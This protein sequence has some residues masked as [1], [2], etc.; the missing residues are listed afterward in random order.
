MGLRKFWVVALIIFILAGCGNPDAETNK[1]SQ[2]EAENNK[3]TSEEGEK[4][5]SG[6]LDYDQFTIDIDDTIAWMEAGPGE[7]SGDKYDAQAVKEEIAQWPEGLS[8]EEY[9][10]RILALTAEDFTKY[11]EFLDE[12]EVVFNDMTAKPDG[13]IGEEELENHGSLNVQILLDAS[14]S[15]AQEIDGDIKMDLAKETIADFASNLPENANVSLRVYGHKGTNKKD[16]KEESCANTEEVYALGSYE[17]DDFEK[18]LN[19]FEPTGYT[20]IAK[21]IEEAGEDL[22]NA[23]GEETRSIV[24][25]VSDGEETCGGDPAAA[26]KDLQKSD[27]EAIVNIIGLD[28]EESERESLEEIA[29]AGEG[30]YFSAN[31]AKEL[32]E[33]FEKARRELIKDWYDWVSENVDVYYDQQSEYVDDSYDYES[34]AVN[35]SYD[36]ETRQK[37]L[38]RYM[39]DIMEEVDA[40]E[41]RNLIGDRAYH[42][43]DH[44]RDEYYDIR[45]EARDTGYELREKA[46]DEGY[47]QREELRDQNKN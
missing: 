15:M 40:V 27:I 8:A 29:S 38:T 3:E 24:Y 5:T 25:V 28:I 23:N 6:D 34:E 45:E 21:A 31:N 11:Q 19:Q 20:P 16:G 17:E 41:I 22:A 12:T 4:D 37:D 46:R 18:S 35:L 14:G 10:H 42:I 7:Y 1:D 32:Q 47:E 44:V 30:E 2:R 13:S 26:A 36:E 33:T 43:R 39:E 9:F